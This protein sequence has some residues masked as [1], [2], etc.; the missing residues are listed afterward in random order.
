[1]KPVTTDPGLTF[2]STCLGALAGIL[3]ASPGGLRAADDCRADRIELRGDWGR[4]AFS[5]E[6]ADTAEERA[7]GL[8]FRDAMATGAG[9]IFVYPEPGP[10]A[11]WMKN[12]RIPLDMI[13]ADE[14]GQILRVH[15][16][17]VP[18][19]LTPIDGGDGVLV[20]LEING[21]LAGR[22]GIEPGDVMRHPAFSGPAPLWPC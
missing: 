9:M 18:G 8:M 6:V 4:A 13:F 1:M 21:G 20:V 11:F 19:D 15:D 2:K 7:Q 17:A 10:V 22:L 12:T 16:N 3:I 14:N 5:V